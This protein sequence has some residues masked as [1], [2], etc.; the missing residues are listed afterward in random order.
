MSTAPQHTNTHSL[1]EAAPTPLEVRL[2][3]ERPQVHRLNADQA[4]IGGTHNGEAVPST[5]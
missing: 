1:V 2:D 4:E 3:W 5:S